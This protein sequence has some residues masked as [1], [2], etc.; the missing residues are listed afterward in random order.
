MVHLCPSKW[1]LDLG[2]DSNLCTDSDSRFESLKKR[3]FDKLSM[4][5]KKSGVIGPKEKNDDDGR[6]PPPD[7]AARGW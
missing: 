5:G 6:D 1:D 4:K 3:I 2:S 7:H